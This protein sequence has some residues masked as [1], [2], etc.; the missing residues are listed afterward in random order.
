M[1]YQ[2]YHGGFGILPCGRSECGNAKSDVEPRYNVNL[3]TP[4]DG[5]IEVPTDAALRFTTYCFS[6]WVDIADVRVHITEDEG[7]TWI[8]AFD[9]SDFHAPY[10]GLNSKIARSGHELIVYIQKTVSWPPQ[11]RIMVK[12]TGVDEFG[13]GAT[14]NPPVVW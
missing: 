6:S 2:R 12:F 9:G 7:D 1:A 14:K 8:L 11:K 13:Q 10:D 3:S 5:Q 4:Q